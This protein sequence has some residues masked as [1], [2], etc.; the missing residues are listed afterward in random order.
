MFQ[1]NFQFIKRVTCIFLMILLIS[2]LIGC[3]GHTS[4]NPEAITLSGNYNLSNATSTEDGVEER[5]IDY[6]LDHCKAA[7]L[8]E[9]VSCEEYYAEEREYTCRIIHDYFGNINYEGM[10]SG[11]I[12]VLED[13]G[14]YKAGDTA[15][16]FLNYLA[17]PYF[18][19][20]HI[21]FILLLTII[22]GL[23]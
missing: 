14:V 4:N 13:E 6:V 5:N 19:Y 2:M 7:V 18:P 21:S 3:S 15:F 1:M 11:Y 10:E 17:S 12:T 9:I 22:V 23:H 8:A 20:I 16:L